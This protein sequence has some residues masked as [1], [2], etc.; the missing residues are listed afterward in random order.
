VVRAAEAEAALV[1]CFDRKTNHCVI[2]PVCGLRGAL[3]EAIDAFFAT[4][5]RY[6]LDDITSNRR[7]LQKA[8]EIAPPTVAPLRRR[9]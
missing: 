9:S 5:D 7:Q 4:L 3:T 8:L 1:E 2:T 6:T